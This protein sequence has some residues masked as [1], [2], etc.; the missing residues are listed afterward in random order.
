MLEQHSNTYSNL[1]I[2]ISFPN[3]ISNIFETLLSDMI[4]YTIYVNVEIICIISLKF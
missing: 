2:Y 3:V 4:L 1:N